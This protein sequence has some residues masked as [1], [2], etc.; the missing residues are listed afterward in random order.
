M[1]PAPLGWYL[2]ILSAKYRHIGSISNEVDHC[3]AQPQ[4]VDL[5]LIKIG[6]KGWKGLQIV[7]IVPNKTDIKLLITFVAL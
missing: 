2:V 5:K 1:P 7:Q 3:P 4:L 6:Y